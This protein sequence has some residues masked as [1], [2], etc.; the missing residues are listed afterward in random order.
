MGRERFQPA[1]ISGSG[2]R[3]EDTNWWVIRQ[4]ADAEVTGSDAA[5]AHLCSTYWRPI[6]SY[7]R[8]A[9]YPHPD[10]EDLTQ[11]F[12]ARLFEKN[13]VQ[14][15]Q[16]ERGKFRSWLLLLLKRFI[17]D[18]WDRTHRQK[19][20]GG[21]TPLA[22]DADPPA[23]SDRLEAADELTPDK[24]FDR[25]WAESVL[26]HA[27]QALRVEWQH[28]NKP[29]VFETLEPFI[30]C[31]SAEHYADAAGRLGMTENHVKVTVH[32]MRRRLRDLLRAEIART[33]RTDEELEE[34]LQDL[35]A[36]FHEMGQGR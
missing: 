29:Q 12:F 27:L 21:Q 25:A 19:R 14:L 4:A 34:E 32:R 31:R 1:G 35:L 18:Q 23:L 30:T 5:R 33:A 20:G 10:A 2:G 26:E 24:L 16:R 22:L 36:I 11:E 8:R 17:A 9:G 28:A 6:Y 7:L 3:F 15:A 13:L